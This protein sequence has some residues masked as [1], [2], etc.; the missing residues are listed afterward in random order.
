MLIKIGDR[1]YE[2]EFN[3]YTPI[4]YSQSFADDIGGGRT[5]PR[6]IADAVSCIAA[7][8]TEY[9][10]PAIT[11]LLEI[12]YSCIRTANPKWRQGF[13][14]WAAEI[15]GSAFSLESGDGWATGVM[16]IVESN[17][18][19]SAAAAVGAKGAK[20]AA[21]AAAAESA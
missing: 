16:Q 2:A 7:S 1:E 8:L 10:V 12:L 20:D 19:P 6:D 13:K 21:A 11:P 17:F 5:R 18:F 14:D 15:P 4:V 9:G 3:G